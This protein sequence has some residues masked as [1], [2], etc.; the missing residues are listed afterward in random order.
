MIQDS[1]LRRKQALQTRQAYMGARLAEGNVEKSDGQS[2]HRQI[3][4]G[5]D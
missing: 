1:L 2:P 4:K 5:G 3:G